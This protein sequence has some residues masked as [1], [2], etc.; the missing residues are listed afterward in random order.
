MIFY[1]TG[2]GNSLQAA[3]SVAEH[4]KEKLISI[5][6]V[7]NSKEKSTEFT[8]GENETIGFVYPIYAWGP[9]KMVLDF[10]S[11]LKLNNYN[12]NYTFSIATCGDNIGNAMK[13]LGSALKKNNLNLDS[14]FSIR[15]PN[16]YIIL[17]NVD[18]KEKEQGKLQKAEETLKHIN[19]FVAERKKGVFE[20][21][22]GPVPFIFTSVINPAF[23]RGMEHTE[24]FYANDSC[25]SCGICE[26]VC[27]C[28]NIVVSEK[29]QWGKKCTQCL[30]CI[31]YC[32][33]KAV[34][35]GKG[36]EKKGRYR[37]PNIKLEEMI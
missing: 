11:E 10:I 4:N 35:Y 25:T 8:L 30:A 1:F 32:P 19:K 7:M 13:L 29:P 17:G 18:P 12:N 26:R 6:K 5:A 37:N 28:K 9:P 14:A 2:T 21:V 33:S 16:N 36:T 23:S 34:Q 31:H 15:M 22:K 3:K 24:K 20:L 27:N